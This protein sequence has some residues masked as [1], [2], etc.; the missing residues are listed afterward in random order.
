MRGERIFVLLPPTTR[1]VVV[2]NKVA[3]HSLPEGYT[4]KILNM[5]FYNGV[6]IAPN[7][8][9]GYSVSPANFYKP[10]GTKEDILYFNAMDTYIELVY[11]GTY[12]TADEGMRQ[13]WYVRNWNNL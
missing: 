5:N 4:V 2:D 3:I 13:L 12:T 11:G 9:D 8:M 1:Q 7:L 6:Y 10:D